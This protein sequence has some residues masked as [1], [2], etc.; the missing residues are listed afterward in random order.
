MKGNEMTNSN[1]NLSLTLLVLSVACFA[2]SMFGFSF[3]YSKNPTGSLFDSINFGQLF[4]TKEGEI[5]P[6]LVEEL[7]LFCMVGI[8]G[9]CASVAFYALRMVGKSFRAATFLFVLSLL[10]GIGTFLAMR[11]GLAQMISTGASFGV[12]W[13]FVYAAFAILAIGYWFIKKAPN[14]IKS[15]QIDLNEI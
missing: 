2:A 13:Y 10:V 6:R 12:S 15:E 7:R 14:N 3:V 5:I 11:L 1:N 4:I 9:F 8:G